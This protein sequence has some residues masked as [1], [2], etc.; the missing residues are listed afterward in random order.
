MGFR[1]SSKGI[2]S[3]IMTS[4]FSVAAATKV[5]DNDQVHAV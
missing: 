3:R 2:F 5:E 4:A 1:D